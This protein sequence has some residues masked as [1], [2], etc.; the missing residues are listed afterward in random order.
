MGLLDQL[1]KGDTI[2]AD[3]GFMLEEE[4]LERG[5]ILLKPPTMGRGRDHL[6]PREEV[7]TKSIACVRIYVEHVIGR[8]KDWKILQHRIELLLLPIL[9]D[10]I[11]IASF[12]HNS[13]KSYIT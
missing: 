9:P 7:V 4:C 13:S 1:E 5:L 11:V 10:M 3:R 2:M 12:I 8:V 6:T